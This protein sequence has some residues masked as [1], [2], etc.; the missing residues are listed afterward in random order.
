MMVFVPCRV[1]S[2]YDELET[3]IQYCSIELLLSSL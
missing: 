3:A 2:Q 1:M